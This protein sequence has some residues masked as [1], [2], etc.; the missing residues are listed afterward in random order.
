MNNFSQFNKG[1]FEFLSQS[2]TP[3]HAT[4]IIRQKLS[5][6]GFIQLQEQQIWNKLS[7]GCGYF[8]IR[9]SGSI[10]AFILGEEQKL[11][12]GFQIVGAHTDSPALQIKP[13]AMVENKGTISLGVE[14]YGGPLLNTWF[15]RNLSLAGRV[16][17]RNKDGWLQELLVDFKEPLITIPSL[18]IHLDRDANNN[19]SINSQKDLAPLFTQNIKE[20][21]PELGT[22]IK[23]QLKKQYPEFEFDKIFSFELFCYDTQIPCYTGLNREF[24]S[25]SRLDNLLSCYCGLE[26]MLHAG[27]KKNGILLCYNHEEIG[28]TTLSGANGS[29]VEAVF[30]RLIQDTNQRRT[31]FA[32]SF[33]ISMDNAH[34]TH[35]N[36]S[37]KSDPQHHIAMNEGVVI[38]NNA[39]QR[40]ASNAYSSSLLKL[41]ADKVDV[42]V[43]EFVMRSDMAC[44]STIGSMTAAKL[45]IP[46]VDVGAPTLAMHSIR[47]HTGSKDPLDLFSLCLGFYSF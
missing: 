41:V 28:S 3:F 27:F 13:N 19:R 6:S 24:I 40:Y 45:G 23:E 35:P 21:V 4:E 33:H 30:E 15:D 26:A 12:D 5:D 8:V 25:A 47:E 42:K 17:V 1:L 7:R 31:C 44:G 37:E 11:T 20:Q 39:K 10:I 22:I 38:K 43:Q 32:N 46:T 18:A 34:A 29:F 2:P 36:N 9:D 14:V 16:F